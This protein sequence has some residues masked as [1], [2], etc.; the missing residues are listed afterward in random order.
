MLVRS[1]PP[2]IHLLT[3]D[4]EAD[5]EAKGALAPKRKEGKNGT[6]NESK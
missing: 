3:R 5:A 4:Q 6:G 2:G 1:F